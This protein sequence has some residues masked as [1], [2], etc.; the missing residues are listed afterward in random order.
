MLSRSPDILVV[1]TARHGRE[2]LDLI[3]R[4]QPN[5]ICT[6]LHMPQMNGL[7]LTQQV[8]ANHPC[9]ILVISISSVGP[10]STTV[11][12]LL[13]AGAID[14]FPKPRGGPGFDFETTAQELISKIK[15]VAGV[16]VFRRRLHPPQAMVPPPSDVPQSKG[17]GPVRLVAIGASTGGPQALQTILSQLPSS[18]P[19]PI[20]CV[21]HIGGGFLQGL[22]DWLQPQ[23][24]L[25]VMIAKPGEYPAVG[26]VYFA[27]E[28]AHLEMDA[29]GR[30]GTTQAPPLEGH[31]PSVSVTLRSVARYYGRAAIGVLLT[32]MGRDGAE[33]M[34]V[35]AEA[36]GFT[37]AEDEDSCV[38]FGMPRQAIEL[39]AVRGV[40]PLSE[41]ASML[42]GKVMAP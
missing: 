24:A 8:M 39:G 32:G 38:V 42:L 35:L 41:I 14:M 25:R 23:T 11:F 1:G 10:D 15:I 12:Q 4:I 28:G 5:V 6:D 19:V 16:Y 3:P 27:P 33:G 2:A 31:R 30:L 21:Q 29:Q 7:E 20:F 18:F 9:P 26:S 36:G 17:H 13:E 37:I 34:R 40:L 22:V